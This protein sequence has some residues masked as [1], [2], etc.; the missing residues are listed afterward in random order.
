MKAII[1]VGGEGTRLRPLTLHC[2]KSTVPMLGHAFLEY[3][4]AFL[5]KHGIRDIVLSICHQPKLLR[6][7][8]GTG[9]RFGIKL[10]Y[11]LESQPLGTAGAIRNAGKFIDRRETVVVLNGDILTDINLTRMATVHRGQRSVLTIGLTWVEDPSAYGL[12]Q[13]SRAG[14]V[15]CFLEKPSPGEGQTH[16]INSGVYIFDSAVFDRIPEGKNYSSERQL[17]PE[18]LS[19]GQRVWSFPGRDY[20]MDIGTPAKYLQAHLDI[21]E[22]RMFMLPIGST[23]KKNS[24]LYMGKRCRFHPTVEVSA[25]GVFGDDCVAA[26]EARIGEF[27]ILGQRVKIGPHAV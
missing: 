23:G 8:F 20:W 24:R 9:R 14:R 13:T 5:R 1:L 17:F 27:A 25:P 4:F 11:A 12:V 6:A 21:L 10:H 18:L 3:Q 22:D 16:W 26:A 15:S 7:A 2:P 19:A